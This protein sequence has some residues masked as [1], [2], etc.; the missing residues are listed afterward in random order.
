L[1][2][3]LS[4]SILILSDGA[5]S[6]SDLIT[7]IV[8]ILSVKVSKKPPDKTHPFGHGRM[9]DIGGFIVSFI[10]LL[11]GL[12]FIKASLARFFSP[13]EI[14]ITN[15]FIALVLATAL[16]KLTLAKFT[17]TM[18][19]RIKSDILRSDTLHHYSD[20]LISLCAGIGLVLIK[21]GLVYID[22]IGGCLV[23]LFIIFLA[24]MLGKEFM[25]KL[26]GRKPPLWIYQKIE[27]SVK[28][29]LG[30]RDL[31]DINIHSYGRDNIISFH[32]ELDS[33]LSLEEAHSVA[34]TIE[35]KIY[36]EGLGR[37]IVHV[38]L[39]KKRV[40]T[41]KKSIED[42]IKNLT[43]L[44]KRV[45]GFHGIEILNAEEVSVLNFHLTVDKNT[46]LEESHAI[47]HQLSKRLKEDFGFSYVN[48]H[49]EPY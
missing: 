10:I 11:M 24:V 9:E 3:F 31:H 37:C 7:T 14:K 43:S 25:D 5:H 16:V 34:D 38:D 6:L 40:S 15:L 21:R 30:V 42:K 8:V 48:I 41:Q 39:T 49:I 13:V 36:R 47:S 12:N 29:V 26:I 27:D 28:G 33:D 22:A 44:V 19:R 20:F 32:I 35:K 2:G 23:S 4:R 46:S 17:S 1:L 18:A 45:K